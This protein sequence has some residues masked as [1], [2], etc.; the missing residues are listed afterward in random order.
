M[1]VCIYIY[2]Y[3]ADLHAVGHVHAAIGLSLLVRDRNMYK[4]TNRYL[5]YLIQNRYNVL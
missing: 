4:S 5:Q 3:I 1:C 2:I